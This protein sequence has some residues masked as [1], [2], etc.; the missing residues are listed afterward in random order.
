[1]RLRRRSGHSD[2]PGRGVLAVQGAAVTV[3]MPDPA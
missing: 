1:L 2:P 3:Q